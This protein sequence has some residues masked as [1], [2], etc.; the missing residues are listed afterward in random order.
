MSRIEDRVLSA[1]DPE[2]YDRTH[3]GKEEFVKLK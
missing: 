1:L 2:E 3:F